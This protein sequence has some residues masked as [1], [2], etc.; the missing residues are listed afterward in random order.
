M[1]PQELFM[2]LVPLL[3]Y[4][5]GFIMGLLT[6][7]RKA[8][9]TFTINHSDPEVDLCRLNLDEDLDFIENSKSMLLKVV[10]EGTPEE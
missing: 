6:N 5:F 3:T 8:V 7:R 2:L 1:R 9:G 4:L 10:V